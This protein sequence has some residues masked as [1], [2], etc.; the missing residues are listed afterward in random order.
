MLF[1]A[2]IGDATL[3]ASQAFVRTFIP[4]AKRGASPYAICNMKYLKQ[5]PLLLVLIVILSLIPQVRSILAR[6]LIVSNDHAAGDACYVLAGG[7]AIWERLGA[8][9]DLYNMHRVPKILLMRSNGIGPYN[10][11]KGTSWSGT[12]WEVQ[13]LIARGVPKEKIELL[14]EID[15]GLGTWNEAINVAGHLTPDIKKIVVVTSAPHTRR[16]VLA[17]RRALPKSVK[18]VPFAATALKL[19]LNLMPLSC[20]N[21][22]SCLSTPSFFIGEIC[23]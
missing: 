22:P 12:Q 2:L 7:N 11:T 16:S 23:G 1:R 6:P 20:L 5:L 13:Y 21:T 18:V 8:A 10:F 17:F 3:F 9:S 14:N 4:L 15:G 19:V